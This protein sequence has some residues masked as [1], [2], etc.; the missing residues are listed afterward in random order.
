MEKDTSIQ[1]E[2]NTQISK[3]DVYWSYLSQFLSISSGILVLPIILN[4]LSPEEIGFNYIL[5]TLTTLVSLFDFGFSSQFGRNIAYVFSGVQSLKQEGVNSTVNTQVNYRL[6]TTVIKTAQYLY[7]RL[8]VGGTL[9]LTTIGSLYIYQISNGFQSIPFLLIIWITYITSTYFNVYFLYYNSL[10]IG[11]GAIKESQ[12]AITTSKLV[13]IGIAIGLL[14]SGFGLL[15]VVI[16]NLIAPFAARYISYHYFY[17]KDLKNEIMKFQITHSEIRLT[18][19]ILWYNARKLGL[20]SL[21]GFV[22]GQLGLFLSGMYLSLEEVASYGLM[23]QLVGIISVISS[24]LLLIQAPSF[25]ACKARGLHQKLMKQFS[26][27]LIIFYALFLIGSI[28]LITVAPFLLHIIKANAILPSMEI[29]VIYSIIRFLESNHSIFAM[30][31]LSNNNVPFLNAAMFACFFTI[32]GFFFI[33]NFTQLGIIG[34]VVVPGI[35]Q[36]AYQNWKWPKVVCNEFHLSYFKI[37]RLGYNE[38]RLRTI[39]KVTRG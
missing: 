24:T 32:I 30:I 14:F 33:L 9:L 17:T 15:S 18:F 13:N 36:G 28:L 3:G 6:L 4:K 22:V 2:S 37:L 25:A 31:L 7:R 38:L 10:L 12:K 27:S 39:L 16:A 5:L 26:Y 23:V 35:V 29:V 8:A 1:L 11:K 21:S 34:L 20:T 19:K